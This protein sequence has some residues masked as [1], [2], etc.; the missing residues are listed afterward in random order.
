MGEPFW[1][2]AELSSSNST[3]GTGSYY[4]MPEE[5]LIKIPLFVSKKHATSYWQ[6]LPDKQR[7]G[8]FGMPQYKLKGFLGFAIEQRYSIGIVYKYPAKDGKLAILP[9]SPEELSE[10]FLYLE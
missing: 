3:E 4:S 6:N 10:D 8:V 2:I 9:I 1:Y 7:F 5:M